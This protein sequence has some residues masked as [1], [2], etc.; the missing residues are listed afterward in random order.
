MPIFTAPS[1]DF[2]QTLEFQLKV[3]DNED[4]VDRDIVKIQV[5]AQ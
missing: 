5:N 2:S 3:T 4:A 1:K